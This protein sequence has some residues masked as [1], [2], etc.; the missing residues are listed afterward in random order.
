MHLVPLAYFFDLPF[1]FLSDKIK[2][3]IARLHHQSPNQIIWEY[4]NVIIIAQFIPT[5]TH[6]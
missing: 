4:L 6:N 5:V 2:G 3:H 1:D